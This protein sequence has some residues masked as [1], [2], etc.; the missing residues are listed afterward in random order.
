MKELQIIHF[1]S[2]KESLN[3]AISVEIHLENADQHSHCQFSLK[4]RE[5]YDY[6]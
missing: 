2:Q 5:C 6:A 1:G 4:A 3:E